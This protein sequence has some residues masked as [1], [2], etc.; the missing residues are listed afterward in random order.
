VAGTLP[1]VCVVVT[2]PSSI[3]EHYDEKSERLFQSRRSQGGSKNLY[4]SPRVRNNPG[5]PKET[6]LNPLN[7]RGSEGT[8]SEFLEYA[9]REDLLPAGVELTDYRQ[10]F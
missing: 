5:Y 10:K 3:I 4:S 2:L 6:I 8:I 7:Q 1:K 9:E